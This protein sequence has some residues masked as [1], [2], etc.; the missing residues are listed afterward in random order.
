[1]IEVDGIE[2]VDDSI[3]TTP[4]S[5][6]AAMAAFPHKDV[7]LIGG[8][9]DRGQQY[10]ALGREAAARGAAV[11]GLPVTG[12]RLIDAAVAAGISPDRAFTV[13]DMTAAV[14]A[15]R[16]LASTNTAVLLT[17]AAPSYNTYRN[18]EERGDHFA[19][20]ARASGK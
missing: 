13:P 14:S 12:E 3:S 19:S 17:P 18:F 5:A 8:G 4:E 20:L 15:A 9:L 10:S 2:W 6:L 7:I 1:M 16:R 11:I